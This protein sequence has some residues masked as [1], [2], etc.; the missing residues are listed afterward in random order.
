M[1][2][3]PQSPQPAQTTVDNVLTMLDAILLA[4]SGFLPGANIADLLVKIAQRASAA[5]EAQTGSPIDPT[6]LKPIDPIP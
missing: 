3:T 1:S 6:L 5:Y 4:L 2:S